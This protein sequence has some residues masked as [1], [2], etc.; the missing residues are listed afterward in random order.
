MT[1]VRPSLSLQ[2]GR[3]KFGQDLKQM[4]DCFRYTMRHAPEPV[5]LLAHRFPSPCIACAAAEASTSCSFPTSSCHLGVDGQRRFRKVCHPSV[6]PNY[7]KVCVLVPLLNQLLSC[8]FRFGALPSCSASALSKPI[9]QK[10]C[11]SATASQRP[12]PVGEL[13]CWLSN[14]I[15][16]KWLLY[17]R[18]ETSAA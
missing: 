15:L 18:G 5:G 17:Y 12:M 13:L 16:K 14:I 1:D 4:Q 11:A 8:C 9:C 7:L 10:G 2:C 3:S 6:P